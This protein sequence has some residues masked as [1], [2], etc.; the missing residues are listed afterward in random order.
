MSK[1]RQVGK[2]L[3][4]GSCC[5]VVGMSG[6]WRLS[7][8]RPSIG[9]QATS[10]PAPSGTVQR[11]GA[12]TDQD[13]AAGGRHPLHFER[14]D[15]QGPSGVRFMARGAGYSVHLSDT[16][17]TIVLTNARDGSDSGRHAILGRPGPTRRRVD[18]R[19]RHWRGRPGGH[20]QLLP[21]QR[22]LADGSRACRRLDASGLP[23]SIPAS[24]P[25]TTA[26]SASFSTTSRS[27][28]HADPSRIAMAFDGVDGSRS[29]PVEIC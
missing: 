10:A 26:T 27:R 15:G 19:S 25:S 20:R 11:A 12:S 16:D 17:A 14:N 13:A 6:I 18:A 2:W 5:L 28:P 8:T 24:T 1:R 9:R 4:M 21:R 29:M 22:P 7:A 23:P 3:V